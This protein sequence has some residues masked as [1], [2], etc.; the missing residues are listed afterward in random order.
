MD[1]HTSI[2]AIGLGSLDWGGL[3]RMEPASNRWGF[4]RGCP[5]DRHYIESFLEQH[6]EDIQGDCLEVMNA[7][8]IRRFGG[9]RVQTENVID[10][11]P[12]NSNA[13]I[14]GDLTDP[15]TLRPEAYDCFILT[16]TLPVIFDSRAVIR[17]AYAALKPGGVL[18]VTAPCLCRYSPHPE[19]FW[20]FTDRSLAR[21]ISENS[22]C[23]SPEIKMHGNLVASIAF[24]TGLA[25][26][27]LSVAELEY[28]DSRFPIVVT[29]RVL[30]PR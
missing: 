15:A 7:N 2:E 9:E 4:D 22:D 28:F 1:P 14:I 10:I 3:R 24:L 16:Q 12:D 19:D 21:L 5:V 30:K 27:E 20:R 11:T 29:A 23:Q 26:E 18:L 6:R 17:N 13:T 25:R 8:Y